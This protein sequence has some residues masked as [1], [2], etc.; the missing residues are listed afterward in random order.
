MENPKKCVECEA[1][2][3]IDKICNKDSSEITDLVCL[4][5]LNFWCVSE[6]CEMFN[7]FLGGE[8]GV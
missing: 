3:F 6:L 8:Q 1:Y 7:H 5:R 2:N 4:M